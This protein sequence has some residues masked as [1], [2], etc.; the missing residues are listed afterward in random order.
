MR[1]NLTPLALHRSRPGRDVV[2][3]LDSTR[4]R[5]GDVLLVQGSRDAIADLRAGGTMLVLD[6]LLIKRLAR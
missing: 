2:G 6:A 4:L 5:A 3:D 1:F